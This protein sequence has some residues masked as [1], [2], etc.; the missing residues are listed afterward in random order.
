MS[1]TPK[2]SG[3]LAGEIAIQRE[4]GAARLQAQAEVMSILAQRE[5]NIVIITPRTMHRGVT[6]QE[7]SPKNLVSEAIK[8]KR[9]V[10]RGQVQER[11]LI[12]V[13]LRKSITDIVDI[14]LNEDDPHVNI[15]S[16]FPRDDLAKDLFPD[17]NLVHARASLSSLVGAANNDLKKKKIKIE[18]VKDERTRKPLSYYITL[19]KDEEDL[20]SAD[21]DKDA[22]ASAIPPELEQEERDTSVRSRRSSIRLGHTLGWN[23]SNSSM[24][25]RKEK[26]GKKTE[27]PDHFHRWRIEEANG[28]TSKGVCNCGEHRDF[29][30]SSED[31]MI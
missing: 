3:D 31:W 17:F 29:K 18:P 30:N 11:L 22:E 2:E 20:D 1:A 24:S 23:R 7:G 10:L 27:K 12:G 5:S 26:P 13:S 15:E 25:G 6:M 21:Q 9:R 16:A 4:R 8:R 28:K 19:I 14:F